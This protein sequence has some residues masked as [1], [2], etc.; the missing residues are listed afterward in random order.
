M[1]KC[2][3]TPIKV[4]M[5]TKLSQSTQSPTT[6]IISIKIHI[7]H[8]Y[9][10]TITIIHY[11]NVQQSSIMVIIK[12]TIIKNKNKL[13]IKNIWVK[14]NVV[15]KKIWVQNNVITGWDRKVENYIKINR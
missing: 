2:Y 5:V 13:I 1:A 9:I 4:I 8:R 11:I 15:T 7:K 6:N 3:D 10:F 14:N 12:I